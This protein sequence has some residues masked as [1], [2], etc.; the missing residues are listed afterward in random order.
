VIKSIY[1]AQGAVPDLLFGVTCIDELEMLA[2]IYLYLKSA[3]AQG[4]DGKV[5]SSS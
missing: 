2:L 5:L 1:F 3:N 4:Y